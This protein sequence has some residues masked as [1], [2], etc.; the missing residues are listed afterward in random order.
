MQDLT[1]ETLAEVQQKMGLVTNLLHGE[2]VLAHGSLRA[3]AAHPGR[4]SSKNLL[5]VP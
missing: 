5:Y 3:S 4:T 2:P 1:G